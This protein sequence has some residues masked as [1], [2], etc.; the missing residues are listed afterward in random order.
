VLV[1]SVRL[2]HRL[3]TRTVIG[4]APSIGIILQPP[5]RFGKK[6]RFAA[7][8]HFFMFGTHPVA[9]ELGDRSGCFNRRSRD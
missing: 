6:I 8:Y 1:R 9:Q 7:P 5:S 4:I 2:N 3:H